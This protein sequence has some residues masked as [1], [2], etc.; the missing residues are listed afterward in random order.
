MEV[1]LLPAAEAEVYSYVNKENSEELVEYRFP[2]ADHDDQV[3]EA[4]LIALAAWQALGC[5]DGG[6]VD[7]RCDENGRPHFL[8][9]N[10]LAG[11]HPFHSDLPI[12]CTNL[13]IPYVTLV[14]RIVRSAAQR[15]RQKASVA[16][17]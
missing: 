7:L 6:R 16:C 14:N 13:D 12:M 10:P 11:L 3:R 2:R 17:L 15:V 9:V 5:R 4:E 1:I 8:E